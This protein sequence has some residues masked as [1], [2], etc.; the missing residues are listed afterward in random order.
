LVYAEV[1]TPIRSPK[2][3]EELQPEPPS[4]VFYLAVKS[5][6]I[7]TKTRDGRSW[8]K[9][10]GSAPDVYAILFVDQIEVAR[11]EVVPNSFE[12]TWTDNK[13]TNYKVGPKTEVRIELWDENVLVAHPICNQVIKDV[14]DAA[15]VGTIEL[16]CDSGASLV[17]DVTAP[18][19][20]I[21][22]GLY[23]E[24]RGKVA[25]VSRVIAA[26]SAGRAGIRP[27]EQLISVRGRAVS[28]LTSGELES[29]L[30]ANAKGG[31]LVEVKGADG[32]VRKVELREEAM[33]PVQ[34]EG[35]DL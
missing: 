4:D 18:K 26:S 6:H 27:N 31:L 28:S 16:N 22:M 1:S 33:Y 15:T 30:N 7:P 12:P 34:G 21:G 3:E 2:A 8:D 35:I 29:I 17:V 9:L 20:K 23:Y 25:R 11:T 14:A 5:A 32:E 13:P 10:G 19:A 24:V